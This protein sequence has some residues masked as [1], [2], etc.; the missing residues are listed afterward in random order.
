MKPQVF[1]AVAF[2]AGFVGTAT[3]Y[4][5][6][7]Q[8]DNATNCRACHG[9]FTASNYTS[10]VDGRSWGN[11]HTLHSTNMLNGDCNTCHK[12]TSRLPVLVASSNGGSGLAAISC[13]GC[14][15][16][17]EDNTS[18]NPEY[19]NGRG[20]GLRQYHHRA[21]I[22]SCAGC[23]ND[24]NP[25]SFTPA[26]EDI[27]PAYYANSGTNHPALPKN[28]CS[29]SGEEN[30][31]GASHGLDN[32]GDGQ[33]DSED[34]DC[35]TGPVCGDGKVDPPETCDPPSS[36]PTSCDDA[37]ACTQDTL[38]GSATNCTASCSHTSVTSC[39]SG[40]GC[41]PAGCDIQSDQDCSPPA[42][43]DTGCG[44]QAGAD[45]VSAG[46]LLLWLLALAINRW[47]KP[48]KSSHSR[49]VL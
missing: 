29:P 41:C 10:K 35:A 43:L 31:A 2:F 49:Q 15:G 11:L 26:G 33:R 32:D 8:N 14:H 4:D 3:A 25:S 34:T 38:N 9:S 42:S 16:R 18:A 45:A 1:L 23:H 20:A 5:R 6:Y 13:M 19:P 22:S 48:S 24:A 17:E 28:P 44:C 37:D 27:K 36:C 39:A 47:R 21:G 12:G 46:A 7:S 40:D 30:F